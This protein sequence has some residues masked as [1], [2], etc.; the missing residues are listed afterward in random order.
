MSLRPGFP[1]TPLETEPRR[2]LRQSEEPAPG[3]EAPTVRTNLILFGLTVFT[4]F[5]AGAMMFAASHELD[6][7][8]GDLLEPAFLA[9]GASFALPLLAILITHEFGHFFAARWHRVPAS[10]PYFIPAPFIPGTFGAVIAMRDTIRSRKALLDIG[11]S[12]P[13]AGLIVALPVLAWGLAQSE[14]L[15]LPPTGYTQE[16]QSILYWGLKRAVVGPIPEGYD[17]LLHPTAHAGWFGLLLTMINLLPWGQL[18]GGHIAYALFGEQHHAIARWFRRSLLVLFAYNV[19]IAGLPL[20]LGTS[21]RSVEFVV[22]STTFWLVWF[23][24]LGLLSRLSGGAEHPPTEP[25]RL[26]PIRR[27]IAWFCLV[28]FVL[29]FMPTPIAYY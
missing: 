5:A 3:S 29:L 11:A 20:L 7:G 1:E 16:G 25:G 15:K 28:V 19:A 26:D 6:W 14:L 2:T 24:L 17:V 13:L 12:G 8:L 23:L 27:G 21:E 4:V 9:R 18:D 22:L 10:Y